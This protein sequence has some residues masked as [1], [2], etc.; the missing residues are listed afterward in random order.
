MNYIIA[1]VIFPVNR[2]ISFPI[3]LTKSVCPAVFRWWRKPIPVSI[4]NSINMV[5]NAV[6]LARTVTHISRSDTRLLAFDDARTERFE[7]YAAAYRTV[8]HRADQALR[9]RSYLR[10][11]LE[12]SGRKNVEGIAAAA[13]TVMMVEAGLP[14][15]LQHFFSNSPWDARW[16]FAATRSHSAID[17]R[18]PA[19]V[20][21]VHDGSFPKKGQSSVGVQ[22]QFAR[23][24]GKKINCQ[25]AVFVTQVGP[26]G[27]FPLV[28]RL[29]LP[30]AWLK[31][32]A[33]ALE[34]TV[35]QEYR[36]PASKPDIALALLDGLRA[37]GEPL[38]VAAEAGYFAVPEFAGG[39]TERGL[40]ARETA[41]DEVSDALAHLEVLKAELGLDHFEGRTWHGWHHHAALV[42]AANY[43][44]HTER[45]H[46]Q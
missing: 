23:S 27:V 38:P 36:S 33:E 13:S 6:L 40:K 24:L 7:G 15:A 28:A 2:T 22:R 11:L 44:L 4:I 45:R 39:L 31:D 8:F 32:N 18:D 16:L 5:D 35:P 25:L 3:N 30:A 1:E 17:R 34:R 12:P 19:A 29:Y 42:V 21:V 10:G 46:T 41:T 37:E 26:A 14:Q 43:F 20:W 9:F